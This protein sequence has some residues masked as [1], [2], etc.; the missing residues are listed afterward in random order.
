MAKFTVNPS[1]E[2]L[3]HA[4]YIMRYLVGTCNYALVFN[5]NSDKGLRAASTSLA[6]NRET[7]VF[8]LDDTYN[9][10]PPLQQTQ[11]GMVLRACAWS[12]STITTSVVAATH[13][14][15]GLFRRGNFVSFIPV[16]SLP[17]HAAAVAPL[18]S[19][20]IRMPFGVCAA[21]ARHTICLEEIPVTRVP[22]AW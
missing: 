16:P 2:H 4:K 11:D 12:H 3:N 21:T 13:C 17:Q 19:F 9:T 15:S 14:P 1:D 18:P 7:E 10:P 22:V 6:C 8:R 20:S 5:G